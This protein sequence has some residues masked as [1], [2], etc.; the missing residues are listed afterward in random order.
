M[1]SE[2]CIVAY[3]S[4]LHPLCTFINVA[5]CS[6]LNYS[7]CCR[8]DL[9]AEGSATVTFNPHPLYSIQ[10]HHSAATQTW[11]RH[12]DE[13]GIRIKLAPLT[14]Q[15]HNGTERSRDTREAGEAG[16]KVDE[17]HGWKQSVM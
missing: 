3:S 9:A 4:S 13:Q 7:H 17:P 6:I 1:V 10:G 12:G 15:H 5:Y 2:S 11:G 16:I 14:S 8:V